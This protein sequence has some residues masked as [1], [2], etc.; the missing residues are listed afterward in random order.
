MSLTS[1][2][3]TPQAGVAQARP[4]AGRGL[5]GDTPDTLGALERLAPRG[6]AGV[7]AGIMLLADFLPKCNGEF[8]SLERCQSVYILTRTNREEYTVYISLGFEN[9][10]KR[11]FTCNNLLR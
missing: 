8:L 9:A 11:M 2:A 4:A 1:A 7:K 10:A 5:L 3:R 6:V